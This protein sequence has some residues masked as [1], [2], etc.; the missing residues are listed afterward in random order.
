MDDSDHLYFVEL[1]L[2]DHS[3]RITPGTPRLFSETRRISGHQYRKFTLFE[4]LV[5]VEVRQRYFSRRD[6]VEILIAYLEEII[7]ELG[8]LPRPLKHLRI[9]QKRHAELFKA[10]GSVGIE[11]EVDQ[12]SLQPCRFTSEY[13]ETALGK[14]H[15]TLEIDPAVLLRQC[16]VL[17]RLKVKRSGLQHFTKLDILLLIGSFG[18]G[19][20]R[21]V[22][23][24][25]CHIIECR[26]RLSGSLLKRY[27][28]LFVGIDLCFE[29]GD[30]LPLTLVLPKKFGHT[31][32]L[33]FSCFECGIG[34]FELCKKR[35]KCFKCLCID[36]FFLQLCR[37][38]FIMVLNVFEVYHV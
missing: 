8:K 10:F 23:N 24:G 4:Y 26:L 21:E 15:P 17:Q 28:R 19:V 27:H 34:L 14:L 29:L 25:K 7:F 1:M 30:I 35:L 13:G 3:A 37:C 16:P 9:V 2:T 36:T 38:F 18:Y 5:I 11:K 32:L 33:C 20:I 6:Q 22:R 12:R 31:V